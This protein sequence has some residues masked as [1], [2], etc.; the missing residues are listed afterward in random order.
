MRKLIKVL[1]NIE[2]ELHTISVCMKLQNPKEFVFQDLVE[3]IGEDKAKEILKRANYSYYQQF[4]ELPDTYELRIGKKNQ[5]VR[6][7]LDWKVYPE[8]LE[9]W[10][11]K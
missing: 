7:N 4:K 9:E 11:R 3:I 6:M 1:M 10:L 8:R 2:K 5:L